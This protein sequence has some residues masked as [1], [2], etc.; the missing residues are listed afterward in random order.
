MGALVLNRATLGAPVLGAIDKTGV[1]FLVT[2]LALLLMLVGLIGGFVYRIFLG[3]T[4]RRGVG[5]SVERTLPLEELGPL[6]RTFTN[7]TP[8]RM[9]FGVSLVVVGA[10]CGVI[11]YL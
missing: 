10:A 5:A 8:W 9:R 2:M 3:V 4:R 11:G 7:Y 6:R 1:E